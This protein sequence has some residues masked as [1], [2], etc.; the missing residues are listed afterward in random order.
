MGAAMT[1]TPNPKWFG[2]YLLQET[3]DMPDVTEPSRP[4]KGWWT[5]ILSLVLVVVGQ[6]QT[7]D[8]M[9]LVSDPKMVGWIVTGLGILM[10]ALRVI[11]GTPLGQSK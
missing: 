8:W 11:T 2:D 5:M 6:L 4:G 3:N 1:V 9:T 7:W 10:A